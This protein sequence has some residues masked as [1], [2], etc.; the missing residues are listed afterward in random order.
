[1]LH[2]FFFSAL[3]FA[4]VFTPSFTT[5][6]AVDQT[7]AV[8]DGNSLTVTITDSGTAVMNWKFSQPGAVYYVI[9]DDTL[10]QTVRAASTTQNNY[11]VTGLTPGS[12]RFTVTNGTDFII[13]D[14]DVIAN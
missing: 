5:I 2:K 14:V 11:T 12:Y 10:P 4:A 8:V 9:V 3:L 13:I 1:M 7:Q 6:Q